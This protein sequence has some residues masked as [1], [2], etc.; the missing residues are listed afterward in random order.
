MAGLVDDMS[1]GHRALEDDRTALEAFFTVH[2]G[3]LL[4]LAG[5]VCGD[6]AAAEDIVQ[7][8]L[9]RAWRSRGSINDETDAPD[10]ARQAHP[11]THRHRDRSTGA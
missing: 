10:L 4:R 8:A 6:L 3:R 7:T 11:P 1:I 2:H 9:E 5:L